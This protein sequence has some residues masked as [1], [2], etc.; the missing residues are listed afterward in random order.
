MFNK[1][2]DHV[3]CEVCSVVGFLQQN[4]LTDRNYLIN[5]RYLWWCD[6]QSFR[7]NLCLMEDQ[8]MYMMQKAPKNSG[9]TL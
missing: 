7:S 4:I 8:Q 3:K 5:K 6:E 2:N 1:I 9:K